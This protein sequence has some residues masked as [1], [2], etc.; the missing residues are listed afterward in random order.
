MSV[1]ISEERTQQAAPGGERLLGDA[2]R[3][4][5]SSHARL[6]GLLTD[7]F[8]PD[9]HRASDRTRAVMAR[10]FDQL[11]GAVEADLRAILTPHFEGEAPDVAAVLAS[12]RV[13][14]ALPILHETGLLR[15][16]DLVQLLLVRAEEHRVVLGLRRIA[17]SGL[18]PA[19]VLSPPDD[20]VAAAADHALRLAENDRIDAAYEPVLAASDLPADL[21][22]RVIWRVAAALRDYLVRARN[23]DPAVADRHIAAAGAAL[24]A[25][26]DADATLEAAALRLATRWRELGSDDDARLH[27]A[28]R[29]GR[30]VL[31]AA[32]LAVRAGIDVDTATAM[33]ADSDIARLAVLLRAVGVGRDTAVMIL[34]EM[35]AIHGLEEQRLIACAD[36]YGRLD[37]AAARAALMPPP[38]DPGYRS[39]LAALAVERAP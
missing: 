7:I 3:A 34:F 16:T 28:L 24:L 33:A 23:V 25:A 35:A 30:F 15:D 19:P 10:L 27:H 32:M 5:E 13:A 38:L 26:H 12:E 18:D 1:V 14:I 31:F 29:Q 36:A 17:E 4:A 22:R 11:V 6:A 8:L 37:P 39:A 21:L 2:A 20:V 9:A